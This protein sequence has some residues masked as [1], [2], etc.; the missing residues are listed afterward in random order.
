M[1]CLGFVVQNTLTE[2]FSGVILKNEQ[3]TN[4]ASRVLL[5]S[6]STI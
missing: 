2:A 1:F 4:F 6:D 3:L 5:S